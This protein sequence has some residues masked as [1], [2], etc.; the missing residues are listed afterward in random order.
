MQCH[1]FFNIVTLGVV[2]C[3]RAQI[4]ALKLIF[5]EGGKLGKPEK[6]HRVRST[7]FSPHMSPGLNPGRSG[8]EGDHYANPNYHFGVFS[9]RFYQV[10]KTVTRCQSQPD[11]IMG[12][13]Y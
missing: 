8:M 3:S 10:I 9:L 5:V 13:N 7:H 1:G 2:I 12:I 11:D 4:L 6:T